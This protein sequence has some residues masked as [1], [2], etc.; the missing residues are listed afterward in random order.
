MFQS[1]WSE[2]LNIPTSFGNETQLIFCRENV[3]PDVVSRFLELT[4]SQSM[5]V[6]E[7]AIRADGECYISNVGIWKLNLPGVSGNETVEEQLA[8]WL[9]LLQ[10]KSVGLHHLRELGYCPYLD[11]KASSGSLS[12]CIDPELLKAIGELKVALSIWL[13]EQEP[14]SST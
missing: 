12:L 5:K 7:K 13:Y 4:P 1:K 6:G 2:K 9:I 11:C 10:P 3:D 8:L 14:T